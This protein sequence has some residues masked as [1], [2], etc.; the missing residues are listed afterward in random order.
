MQA[1]EALEHRSQAQ[2]ARMDERIG[3]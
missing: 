1:L 3:R 2:A